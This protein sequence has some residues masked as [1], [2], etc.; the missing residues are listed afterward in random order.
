MNPLYRP[1]QK[2]IQLKTLSPTVSKAVTALF[3]ERE[4][5]LRRID[6]LIVDRDEW[7]AQYV[8]L[9]EKHGL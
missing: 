7:I 1:L 9:K 4:Q 6:D 2:L 8:A 3:I 5:L